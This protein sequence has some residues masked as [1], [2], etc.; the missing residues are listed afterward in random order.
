M[1]NPGSPYTSVH[2]VPTSADSR[3]ASWN[4]LERVVVVA[5]EQ[6]LGGSHVDHGRQ[7]ERAAELPG[8]PLRLGQRR[9]GGVE[10]AQGQESLSLG[11]H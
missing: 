1:A 5:G 10:V 8:E 6:R 11:E 3:V 2:V 4:R 9:G 7:R